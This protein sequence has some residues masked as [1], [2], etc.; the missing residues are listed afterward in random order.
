M[1]FVDKALLKRDIGHL[2]ERVLAIYNFT[3]SIYASYREL[4]KA[5]QRYWLDLVPSFF[6]LFCRLHL[7]RI[8]ADETDAVGKH[9]VPS[10]TNLLW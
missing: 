4:S 1:V 10:Q 7:A 6:S 9:F 8:E 3:K 5:K 2:D